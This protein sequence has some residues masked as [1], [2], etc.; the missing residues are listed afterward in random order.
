MS[1][2]ARKVCL[3]ISLEYSASGR[4]D[5]GVTQGSGQRGTGGAYGGDKSCFFCSGVGIWPIVEI[6]KKLCRAN[7]SRVV[8]IEKWF[9]FGYLGEFGVNG[10]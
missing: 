2:G 8:G 4:R 10:G 9:G 7:K 1:G 6:E 3:D 5:A